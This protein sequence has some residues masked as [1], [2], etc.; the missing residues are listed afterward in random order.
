MEHFSGELPVEAACGR[1]VD[2]RFSLSLA[3]GGRVPVHDLLEGDDDIS[4]R[5]KV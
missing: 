5:A 3:R 2:V 4:R 1:G